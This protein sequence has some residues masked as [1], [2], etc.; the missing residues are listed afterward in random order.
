MEKYIFYEKFFSVWKLK[1][2]YFPVLFIRIQIFPAVTE[3]NI[4][5]TWNYE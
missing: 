4:L 1:L 2:G 3:G 5:Y